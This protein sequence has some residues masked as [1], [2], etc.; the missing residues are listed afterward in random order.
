VTDN[1]QPENQPAEE[2]FDP[3]R[4]D[5]AERSATLC[6]IL[7]TSG[8]VVEAQR[9][10]E[11]FAT[12][13]AGLEILVAETAGS[14]RPLGLDIL[15]AAEGYRLLT[16]SQLDSYVRQF[17]TKLRKSKLSRS[18]LE[19]L[20]IIAYE[21]PIERSR[22]DDIRQVNSESTIRTLLDRR[23]IK[24]AG[25]TDAPGRPFLYRTTAQFLEIF[26]LDSLDDLPPR[27]AILAE[28]EQGSTAGSLES[29]PTFDDD[30]M[31]ELD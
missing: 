18:S 29:L 3:T 10:A 30:S 6:A 11:F 13:A 2:L 20:A 26:G 19:I 31:A 27:P 28:S 15:R 8:E 22:I 21:Q 25:R 17:H 7:F 1:S 23:L 9:L 14:L 24:V 4:L 12:D 5:A 16:S